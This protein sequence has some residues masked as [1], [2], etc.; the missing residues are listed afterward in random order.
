LKSRQQKLFSYSLPFL[1]LAFALL[2]QWRNQ[3]QIDSL[4]KKLVQDFALL[5]NLMEKI[6]Q[7]DLLEISPPPEIQYYIQKGEEAYW[8]EQWGQVEIP[9]FLFNRQVTLIQYREKFVLAYAV[10]GQKPQFSA[11]AVLLLPEKIPGATLLYRI[12]EE[13]ADLLP[14]WH[15]VTVGSGKI[16]TTLQYKLQKQKGDW[17][18]TSLVLIFVAFFLSMTLAFKEAIQK[19]H[20]Q[21]TQQGWVLLLG[22]GFAWAILSWVLPISNTIFPLWSLLSILIY[23]EKY[24]PHRPIALSKD[25][26]KI[27]WASLNYSALILALFSI[28]LFCKNV[29]D[30]ISLLALVEL[31]VLLL[32]Y[33]IFSIKILR[34]QRE[35]NLPIALQYL[36]MGIAALFLL[37]LMAASGSLTLYLPFLLGT[38]IYW[39][40]L[41]LYLDTSEKTISW[42]ILWLIIA[43]IFLSLS[44][45]Y[46]IEKEKTST[47]QDWVRT[48][49]TGQ[50][51]LLL[52]TGAEI[53]QNPVFSA[54]LFTFEKCSL[55]PEQSAALLYSLETHAYLKDHFHAQIAAYS[56][57]EHSPCENRKLEWTQGKWTTAYDYEGK[58]TLPT[59][60]PLCPCLEIQYRLVKKTTAALFANPE[61][62]FAVY[63][64]QNKIYSNSSFFED[65]VPKSLQTKD[66]LNPSATFPQKKVFLYNQGNTWVVLI[67]PTLDIIKAIS[68]FSYLFTLSVLLFFALLWLN[69]KFDFLPEY[70]QF[71]ILNT[72][73]LR[74][75]LQLSMLGIILFFFVWMAGI[76]GYFLNYSSSEYNNKILKNHAL[77]L[78]ETMLKNGSHPKINLED[79]QTLHTAA[80][81][82][83]IS[84][85]LFDAKGD[86]IFPQS[87]AYLPQK[88]NHKIF[89]ALQDSNLGKAGRLNKE[90]DTYHLP[91][92][93]EKESLQYIVSVKPLGE[94]PPPFDNRSFLTA[95]LNVYVFLLLFASLLAIAVG[96]SVSK[97]L[98]ALVEKLKTFRLGKNNP[99]IQWENNDELGM[100]IHQYNELVQKLEESA[101]LLA[102]TEREVAWREMAKQVAH[103][104]KNPLTPMKLSI[105]YLQMSVYKEGEEL[106]ELIQKTAITLVEQIEN[107]SQIASEFSNFA[108]LP[109][110]ENEVLVL[111]DLVASVHELFRKSGDIR[112]NLYI[113]LEEVKVFADKSHLL[114]VFNNLLKNAIQSIPG[115]RKGEISIKLSKEDQLAVV[116]IKDNGQ[117]I[118]AEMHA[119]VFYPNFTT[120]TSGTGLGLPI[121]KSIL[122]SFGGKIYFDTQ[123]NLG[124]TFTIELPLYTNSQG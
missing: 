81:Y 30:P 98:Q 101:Q 89:L 48:M 19:A 46:F 61:N 90:E 70:L 8:T 93:S 55:S 96:N 104:I 20:I 37:I 26:S 112:F 2:L 32:C 108:K 16:Q 115:D 75:K 94:N 1:A 106:K 35:I 33:F 67:S 114:R 66:L 53:I 91:I 82:S 29:S 65:R 9:D 34:T 107:L 18:W 23:T 123:V 79:I 111:N 44:L 120:K 117:G 78:K 56:F 28:V 27:L 54:P 17:H 58:T 68:L 4:D 105:Q 5:E 85:E 118:P 72:Q 62:L 109:Q 73:T 102:Q 60:N 121:C 95:L 11:K 92:Y 21:K 83:G 13:P 3:P 122:E 100:L 76:T 51:S 10:Q 12:R 50:D 99:S 88:I 103:E 80:L 43:S 38:I 24:L 14:H 47:K 22:M 15:T 110:A 52:R 87:P 39:L 97:P 6:E 119:K 41:E 7:Q 113:S 36:T 84:L 74:Y 116:K 31:L 64:Q 59:Q 49:A 69:H 124:T 25:K 86:R 57:K 77:L 71:E 63:H 45:S 42:F 40:L